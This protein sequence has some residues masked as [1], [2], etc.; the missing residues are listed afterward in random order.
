M[1]T[2]T[3]RKYTEPL[4]LSAEDIRHLA[5][6][7]LENFQDAADKTT[8]VDAAMYYEGNIKALEMLLLHMIGQQDR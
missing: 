7:W 6:E 4:V 3:V 2:T 8:E 5:Q 1:A